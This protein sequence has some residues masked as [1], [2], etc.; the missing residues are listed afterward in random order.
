MTESDFYYERTFD[1]L[2]ALADAICEFLQPQVT[3]EGYSSHQSESAPAHWRCVPNSV[4]VGLIESGIM[5]RL[6]TSASP[7][8]IQRL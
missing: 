4:I 7:I 5:Q 2:E 3:V 1:N 6:E 8:R